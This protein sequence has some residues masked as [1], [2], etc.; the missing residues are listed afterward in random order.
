MYSRSNVYDVTQKSCRR[1]GSFC[2][3]NTGSAQYYQRFPSCLQILDSELARQPQCWRSSD[4]RSLSRG[5]VRL[6]WSYRRSFSPLTGYVCWQCFGQHFKPAMSWC[7][8]FLA[9]KYCASLTQYTLSVCLDKCCTISK[10]AHSFVNW[11][12]NKQSNHIVVNC[13]VLNKNNIAK[14]SVSLYVYWVYQLKYPVASLV[15]TWLQWMFC[16]QNEPKL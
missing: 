8:A 5:K 16:M 4:L 12:N 7:R 6:G 13:D 2:H 11:Y 9:L 15:N 14:K 1:V 10:E 3:L